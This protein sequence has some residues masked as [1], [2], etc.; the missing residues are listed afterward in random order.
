MDNASCW[1]TR[2]QAC[3]IEH[4]SSSTM[5]Q[6]TSIAYLS[7]MLKPKSVLGCETVMEHPLCIMFGVGGIFRRT[8]LPMV[9]AQ[10]LCSLLLSKLQCNSL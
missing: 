6:T 3:P 10:A 1:V 5:G 9:R 4:C 2:S 8:V 7:N